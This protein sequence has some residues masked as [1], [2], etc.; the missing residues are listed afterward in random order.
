MQ[1]IKISKKKKI[2]KMFKFN[3]KNNLQKI[4]ISCN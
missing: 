1:D 3:E 2:N 4:I